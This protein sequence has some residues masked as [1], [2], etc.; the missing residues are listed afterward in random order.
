MFKKVSI[1]FLGTFLFVGA[2]CDQTQTTSQ[3][4]TSQQQT[5]QTVEKSDYT[6]SYPAG[7]TETKGLSTDASPVY[8]ENKFY[9]KITVAPLTDVSADTKLD[10]A[11]CKQMESALNILAS[12]TVSLNEPFER[13]GMEGCKVTARLEGA[14]YIFDYYVYH[15]PATTKAYV[16][17]NRYDDTADKATVDSMTKAA[18]AFQLK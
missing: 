1:L 15:K 10:A 3:Q 6:L 16:V 2:G 9:T 18:E 17:S 13:N 8:G 4:T 12:D 11:G 14:D 5:L 7:Y